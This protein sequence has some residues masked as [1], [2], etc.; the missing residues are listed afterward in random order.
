MEVA[1]GMKIM[2]SD[3]FPAIEAWKMNFL[4]VQMTFQIM[5]KWY[6]PSER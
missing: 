2:D 4:Q 1:G 5:I 3:K 6:I